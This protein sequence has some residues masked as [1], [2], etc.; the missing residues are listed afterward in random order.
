MSAS[1]G[2]SATCITELNEN[3]VLLGRGE[4]AVRYVGNVRFRR[5]L[6]ERRREYAAASGYHNKNEIAFQIVR[7]I[8]KRRGRFLQRNESTTLVSDDAGAWVM[9]DNATILRKVKQA[10]RDSGRDSGSLQQPLL[11]MPPNAA[12]TPTRDQQVPPPAVQ[13]LGLLS[14]RLMRD[15]GPSS[16]LGG[17]QAAREV[18]VAMELQRVQ[19]Q[20]IVAAL[21]QRT[22]T[23]QQ[24]QPVASLAPLAGVS[25]FQR[26]QIQQNLAA[27]QERNDSQQQQGQLSSS[28]ALSTAEPI[29]TQP[30]GTLPAARSQ[31][32]DSVQTTPHQTNSVIRGMSIETVAALRADLVRRTHLQ[33][34]L[35]LE[36]QRLG[37]SPLSAIRRC[38]ELVPGPLSSILGLPG[39]PTYLQ[40]HSVAPGVPN[41]QPHPGSICRNS[42]SFLGVGQADDVQSGLSSISTSWLSEDQVRGS[43]TSMVGRGELN[44]NIQALNSQTELGMDRSTPAIL[45]LEQ[46]DH[47]SRRSSSIFP[48]L[49]APPVNIPEL[50]GIATT[51]LWTSDAKPTSPPTRD[52]KPPLIP[53]KTDTSSRTP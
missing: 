29:D 8:S 13:R 20:Q 12:S 21:K 7:A 14:E 50:T 4:R 18:P 1:S 5:L 23:Q 48:R 38:V 22:E 15:L 47:S 6:R 27:Q 10:F 3:D 28:F 16:T 43:T 2:R 32:F 51:S 49:P 30:P 9:A 37:L 36:G 41:L 35:A 34:A 46:I 11:Q 52:T 45:S 40:Q 42:S 24:H 31:D 33:N 19:L 39:R 53:V 26:A 25:H 17:A 44:A